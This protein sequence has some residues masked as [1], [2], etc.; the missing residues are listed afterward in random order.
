MRVDD[1]RATRTAGRDLWSVWGSACPK[2][3]SRGANGQLS[4]RKKLFDVS[5]SS[6]VLG[7]DTPRR[8]SHGDARG[9]P[10]RIFGA[11][12]KAQY[13]EPIIECGVGIHDDT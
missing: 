1:G 2:N 4:S 3:K 5:T 12:S 7:H 8:A 10:P 13:A 6:E 9:D 11:T